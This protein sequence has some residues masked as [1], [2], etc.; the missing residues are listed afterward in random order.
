M[1]APLAPP[2]P[3]IEWTLSVWPQLRNYMGEARAAERLSD[4][5]KMQQVWPQLRNYMGEAR[6]AEVQRQKTS[7]E[8][9]IVETD[10]ATAVAADRASPLKLKPGNRVLADVHSSPSPSTPS[11]RRGT[12]Q[13]VP[14][15]PPFTPLQDP[16][17]YNRAA[18]AEA[19]PVKAEE[20]AAPEAARLRAEEEEE[21]AAAAEVEPPL[22]HA[23]EQPP[24]LPSAV[25]PQE[26]T[27]VA[28]T[29]R[30]QAEEEAGAEAA[31]LRA[32]E[33]AAA[34]VARLK[35]EEEAAAEA[36][37]SAVAVGYDS[38][39]DRKGDRIV[40]VP[41]WK[42]TPLRYVYERHS[43]EQRRRQAD[44]QPGHR[45]ARAVGARPLARPRL[46]PR[47]DV[48][49]AGAAAC[50]PTSLSGITSITGDASVVE[51]AVTAGQEE[52]EEE[53]E[54]PAIV[55]TTEVTA[56]A[57]HLSKM[58]ASAS[59]NPPAETF[60]KKIV[61][62]KKQQAEILIQN[63]EGSGRAAAV[64]GAESRGAM[65]DDPPPRRATLASPRGFGVPL[66]RREH[67]DDDTIKMVSELVSTF[68]HAVPVAETCAGSCEVGR[69]ELDLKQEASAAEAKLA[70]PEQ[71]AVMAQS[72]E[73]D[74][75]WRVPA[76]LTSF[77]A[78]FLAV[79]ICCGTDAFGPVDSSLLLMV[80]ALIAAVA[81]VGV[82]GSLTE[83]VEK[84]SVATGPRVR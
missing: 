49:R 13:K 76:A 79:A 5:E 41:V 14:H 4:V 48:A 22:L 21:A 46:R 81:V 6:E 75:S 10:Q 35:A 18:V 16:N 58:A 77:A 37:A 42:N 66:H 8:A 40:P 23:A 63:G 38:W 36:A 83:M 73:T 67:D 39:E 61:Q 50:S 54:E 74:V 33:E 51:S 28:E 56:E 15:S 19:A 72:E 60:F 80:G 1:S 53:E 25:P 55:P 12:A 68:E 47:S 70:Q 69:R 78:A 45:G 52:E 57:A 30:V 17:T 9:S 26:E 65:A 34:E 27:A 62:S 82:L 2:S 44:R 20:E 43:A 29:A 59:A 7:A 3:P 64:G 11:E 31:R 32:E 24:P 71:A 84:E